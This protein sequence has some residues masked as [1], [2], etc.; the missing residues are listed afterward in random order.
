MILRK[1]TE[2]SAV[3]EDNTLVYTLI[4]MNDTP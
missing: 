4:R 1:E 2:I 3:K